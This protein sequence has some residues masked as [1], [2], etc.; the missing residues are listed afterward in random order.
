MDL[1][2]KLEKEHQSNLFLFE[3]VE[4]KYRSN[5]GLFERDED[6][7]QS[8]MNNIRRLEEECYNRRKHQKYTYLFRQAEK[9]YLDLTGIKGVDK[10]SN[11][12]AS[13][14]QLCFKGRKHQFVNLSGVMIC[15]SCGLE[16]YRLFVPEYNYWDAAIPRG[17][18]KSCISHRYG[19]FCRRK[20]IT[21][22]VLSGKEKY[23]IVKNIKKVYDAEEPKGSR[24]PN[25]NV[26]TYQICERLD[27][28]L[29]IDETLLKIPKR[30]ASHNLCKKIFQAL[31]WEYI[32]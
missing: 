30:K 2:E 27:I 8:S 4:E 9:E 25:I 31:G 16:N 32:E 12:E 21:D 20:N 22:F 15:H 17:Q 23:E 3:R 26:L 18:N 7:H 28:E 5:V 19:N 6:V 14:Q 13:D 10:Q 24:L 1:L 29:E 11:V